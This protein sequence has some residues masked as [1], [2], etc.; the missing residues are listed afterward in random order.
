MNILHVCSYYSSKLYSLLIGELERL[1]SNNTVF[2]FGKYGYDFPNGRGD[3]VLCVE[4]YSELDRFFFSRKEHKAWSALCVELKRN[5]YNLI[6]AHSLFSN[7]YLALLARQEYGIPYVVAVRNTDINVF[8]K[9]RV[10][11]RK[12]GLEILNKASKIIFISPS[13]I[14]KLFAAYV[15][16]TMRPNLENKV[17]VLP[18]G[19]DSLFFQMSDP[20]ELNRSDTPVIL[21]VGKISRLKNQATT[22]K[23]CELLQRSDYEALQYRVIGPVENGKL[24]RVLDESPLAQRVESSSQKNLIQEYRNASVMCMPSLH[25]T[26]GLA[27]IEAMSQGTP[28]IYSK[29]EGIDGFFSPGEVGYPVDPKS[30]AEIADAMRRA[31]EGG[32][33]LRNRCIERSRAF[34]WDRIAER[35]VREVYGEVLGAAL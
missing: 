22:L 2:Y 3:S 23:A 35:Y 11:L 20:V 16:R 33:E 9:Y 12:L 21:Q 29:G 8:F 5:Q 25:E 30:P 28:V 27:Y 6:H 32:E 19:I 13:Y 24:A 4:C 26:F 31:L 18:N 7:G 17:I 1:R 14:E 34:R 10:H 15:P